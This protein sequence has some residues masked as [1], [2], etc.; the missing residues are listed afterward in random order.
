MGSGDGGD[1]VT[2][3]GSEAGTGVAV[4]TLVSEAFAGAG[5][6]ASLGGVG[7]A[8]EATIGAG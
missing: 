4:V 5:K 2:V 7:E 8:G 6:A 1:A 3:A